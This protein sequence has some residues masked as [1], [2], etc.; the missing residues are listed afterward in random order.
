MPLPILSYQAQLCLGSLLWTLYPSI[1]SGL[2]AIFHFLFLV[3]S[4]AL[5]ILRAQA[6]IR[7]NARVCCSFSKG[8][9][10]V[11]D[12]DTSCRRFLDINMLKACAVSADDF[13]VRTCFVHHLLRLIL[14]VSVPRMPAF[15]ATLFNISALLWR[16]GFFV[17]RYLAFFWRGWKWQALV[18]FL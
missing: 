7:P 13:K 5:T 17:Q 3:Y 8:I 9:G 2:H 12:I 15:P 16:A 10:R 6:R 1:R 4:S 11:G 14:S 18:S